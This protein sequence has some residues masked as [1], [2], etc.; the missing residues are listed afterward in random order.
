MDLKKGPMIFTACAAVFAAQIVPVARTNPVV[1]SSRSI[2]QSMAVPSDVSTILERSCRDCHSNQTTWPWYSR[3]AP[4]SWLIARD[5]REGRR[6]L[7][8]SEWGGYIPRRKDRKLKEMCD[9]V[10]TREMPMKA[11][12]ILHPTAKLTDSERQT[13]CDW[14]EAARAKLTSTSL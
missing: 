6:E 10:R 2:Y 5:V 13:L 3:L 7:N 12:T 8:L 11:Y 4:V 1:E 9:Q 14:S